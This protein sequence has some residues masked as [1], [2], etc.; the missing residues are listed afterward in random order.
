MACADCARLGDGLFEQKD[1]WDAEEAGECEIAKVVYI[2]PEARL[3]VND[4]IDHAESTVALGTQGGA[5]GS[6][7]LVQKGLMPLICC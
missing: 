2:G 7:A 1:N 5:C 4:A 6:G 3:L